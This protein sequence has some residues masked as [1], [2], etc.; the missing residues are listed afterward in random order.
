MDY[1]TVNPTDFNRTYFHVIGLGLQIILV[2]WM[3]F[4]ESYAPID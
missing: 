2:G 3:A 1:L 4:I